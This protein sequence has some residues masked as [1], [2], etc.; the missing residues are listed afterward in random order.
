MT[1]KSVTYLE[2]GENLLSHK[3]SV[4]HQR[5]FLCG[6]SKLTKPYARGTGESVASLL[7]ENGVAIKVSQDGNI[8]VYSSEWSD[9]I[10]F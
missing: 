5:W 6:L 1:Y 2:I 8:K 9:P 4:E 3:I 7:G 10:V